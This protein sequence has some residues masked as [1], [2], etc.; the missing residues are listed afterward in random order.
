MS[1]SRYTKE[2]REDVVR[3]VVEYSC[4]VRDVAEAAGVKPGTVRTWI[5]RARREGIEVTAK[6]RRPKRNV[7]ELAE[8]NAELRKALKAKDKELAVKDKQ[9]A[10]LKKAASFFAAENS[11]HDSGTR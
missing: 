3:Q 1:S 9:V 11:N 7:D 4:P 2:F 5:S 10:F 8:E 6:G